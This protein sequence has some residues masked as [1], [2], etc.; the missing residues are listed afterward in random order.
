MFKEIE[1]KKI[2]KEMVKE[3]L[4][5]FTKELDLKNFIEKEK[6]ERFTFLN[7]EY[8]VKVENLYA[9]ALQNN[10]NNTDEVFIKV[11][12]WEVPTYFKE[13]EGEVDIL[14]NKNKLYP[15]NHLRVKTDLKEDRFLGNL[16]NG[17]SKK[18]H[19]KS[20][21]AKKKKKNRKFF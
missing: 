14:L 15:D 20:I 17:I 8:D 1:N 11:D 6:I 12:K 16:N 13:D 21:L 10:K 19:G 2:T 4:V 9:G 7:K 3:K 5:N 18:Q